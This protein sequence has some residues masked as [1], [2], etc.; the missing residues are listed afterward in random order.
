[1]LLLLDCVRVFAT[2]WTI[3]HQASL[4]MEFSR[5]EDWDGLPFPIPGDL[6]APGIE[7]V[8]L[9]SPELAGIFFT[10]TPPRKHIYD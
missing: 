1:M 7:L 2:P 3:A 10:T 4:S 9:A 8:S 5:Q 6:L